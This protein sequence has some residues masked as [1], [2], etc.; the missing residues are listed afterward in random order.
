MAQKVQV[1]LV[2]DV[3]GGEAEETVSFSVD[4]TNYEI[5]LSGV[6]AKQLR[7]AV[8]PFLKAARKAPPKQ[9]RG[10]RAA[11]QRTAPNRERSA[12]IRAWAKEHGKDVSERGRIPQAIVDE[13]YARKR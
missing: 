3:D 10:A 1:L 9:G 5:D 11:K 13:F 2:D 7:E 4:G 12:E 8:A 6:H